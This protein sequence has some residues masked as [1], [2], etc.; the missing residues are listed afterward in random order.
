MHE[1]YALQ[2]QRVAAGDGGGNVRVFPRHLPHGDGAMIAIVERRA[3]GGGIVA[4]EL[5]H[6][7]EAIARG[8]LQ[9]ERGFPN[10]LRA[11]EDDTGQLVRC[12]RAAD[13]CH[14]T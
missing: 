6:A 12:V 13:R 8:Q 3:L 9:A 4:H 7:R 1:V 2:Q 11:R 10:R 5:G 14:C